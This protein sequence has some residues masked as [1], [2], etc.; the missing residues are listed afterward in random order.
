M[1]PSA[2]RTYVCSLLPIASDNRSFRLTRNYI[3]LHSWRIS[4][5]YSREW[6][7]EKFY[8]AIGFDMC[9][10]FDRK[11]SSR[12]TG[13]PRLPSCLV[14]LP[15]FKSSAIYKRKN[16]FRQSNFADEWK[17]LLFT[18]PKRAT[19]IFCSRSQWSLRKSCAKRGNREILFVFTVRR[20]W[21]I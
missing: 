12:G 11:Q 13:F 6:Y 8:R 10:F 4:R 3:A 1:Y 16:Y 7:L 17:K 20:R 2:W 15:F 19:E 21:R 18:D 14:D 5:I 9:P